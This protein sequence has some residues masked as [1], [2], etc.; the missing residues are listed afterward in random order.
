MNNIC[1]KNSK[2]KEYCQNKFYIILQ[3]E[4]IFDVERENVDKT[5]KLCEI[6]IIVFC[7][8]SFRNI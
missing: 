1:H 7:E 6:P 3:P 4:Q 5:I 2:L 8:T